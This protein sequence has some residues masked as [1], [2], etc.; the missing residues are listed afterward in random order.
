MYQSTLLLF[1]WCVLCVGYQRDDPGQNAFKDQSLLLQ[2][3]TSDLTQIV[4]LHM[5]L[6]FIQSSIS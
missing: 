3:D 4:M 2:N 6:S 5:M 1:E